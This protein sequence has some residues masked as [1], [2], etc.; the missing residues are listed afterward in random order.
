MPTW[1]MATPG[2]CAAG[3]LLACPT[4]PTYPELG[5]IAQLLRGGSWNNNPRNCRSAYRN[6]NQ[7]G[8]ANNNVSFRVVC[9]PQH[10]L[11]SEPLG[12]IP[13]GALEGTRPAP[14]ISR[15]RPLLRIAPRGAPV[16]HGCAI[17]AGSAPC[18]LLQP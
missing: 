4:R 12:G 14:E 8:N 5:R 10:P 13:A 15:H 9:L 3:F 17:D 1:P 2:G 18:F 6:H 7:P 16:A 11:L